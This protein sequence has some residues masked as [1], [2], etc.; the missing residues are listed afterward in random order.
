MGAIDL[1]HSACAKFGD[2]FVGTDSGARGERHG[3]G[4]LHDGFVRRDLRG[5]M[6]ARHDAVRTQT[7]RPPYD[8][9]TC[10]LSPSRC[11]RSWPPRARG[12]ALA[13]SRRHPS[14]AETRPCST[15]ASLGVARRRAAPSRCSRIAQHDGAA[16]LTSRF[17]LRAPRLPGRKRR[18][19]CSQAVRAKAAPIL[20]GPRSAGS[21]R[22]ARHW[23]SSTSIS[24]APAT[25]TRCSVPR[26]ART[27][28]Q[29][30]SATS[31]I[32]RS[33]SVAARSSSAPRI[34]PSTRPTTPWRTSTT[35]A[36][37][38]AT[39]ASRFTAARTARAW[40]RPTCA[41][42]HGACDRR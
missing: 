41:G 36:R 6:C 27:I 2:D 21:R 25:P 4:S 12:A 32:P 29:A 16:R 28:R 3:A 5:E 30:S 38:S 11:C 17:S 34:S 13:T 35:C 20:R 22:C 18:C 7:P 15:R 9:W 19:S 39:S 24:A 31:S 37:R 40:C 1:A 8:P 26:M 14:S 10:D 42:L 23:I 33:S